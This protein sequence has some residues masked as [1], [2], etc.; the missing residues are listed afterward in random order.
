MGNV[1]ALEAR[2]ARLEVR[3]AAITDPEEQEES[4]RVLLLHIETWFL[5]GS[6]EDIPK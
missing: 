4:E 3:V 1:K 6:F 2:L 5:G